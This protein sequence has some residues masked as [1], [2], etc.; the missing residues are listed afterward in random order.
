MDG[1]WLE[2]DKTEEYLGV[3]SSEA[4]SKLIEL[5]KGIFF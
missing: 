3:W 1:W 5:C 2:T 4:K